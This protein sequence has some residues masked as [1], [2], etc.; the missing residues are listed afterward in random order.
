MGAITRSLTCAGSAG[1]KDSVNSACSVGGSVMDSA[2]SAGDKG[3]SL[4]EADTITLIGT[5][6]GVRPARVRVRGGIRADSGVNSS[7]ILD[8]KKRK[9]KVVPLALISTVDQEVREKRK[10]QK[11]QAVDRPWVCASWMG[12]LRAALFV[13][14]VGV[15]LFLVH[16]KLQAIYYQTCKANLIAVVL[17]NRSD[18]CYGLHLA[19]SAIEKGYH[20]GMVTLMHWGAS[21]AALLVP[22]FFTAR[23]AWWK[24]I[25]VPPGNV[26]MEAD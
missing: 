11:H 5:G 25:P 4:Q 22:C 24:S 8:C 9:R 26:T 23:G 1:S 10:K 16:H 18:V 12:G 2:V 17:H 7:A 3:T 20:Q 13:I 6:H 19:I 21:A 14:F 15:C